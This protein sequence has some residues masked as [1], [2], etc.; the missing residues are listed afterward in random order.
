MEAGFRE[1]SIYSTYTPWY[2]YLTFEGA[3]VAVD[4]Q[5]SRGDTIGYSGNT[6]DSSYPHLHFFA[7]QIVKE[8]HDAKSKNR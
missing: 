5:V 3:S 4:D 8:C 2:M 7:Q 1:S 6:G